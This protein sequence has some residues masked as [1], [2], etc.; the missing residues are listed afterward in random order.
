[1]IIKPLKVRFC[2]IYLKPIS[3]FF[4]EKQKQSKL[5]KIFATCNNVKDLSEQN[6]PIYF[7]S[8][9]VSSLHRQA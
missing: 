1:M 5:N 3:E 2:C 6:L 8:L 9:S 4:L 7:C